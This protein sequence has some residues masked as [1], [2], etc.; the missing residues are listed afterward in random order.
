MSV[1]RYVLLRDHKTHPRRAFWL[2]VAFASAQIAV[3]VH[4]ARALR[5]ARR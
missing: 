5:K 4:N 2:A 3:D 1:I